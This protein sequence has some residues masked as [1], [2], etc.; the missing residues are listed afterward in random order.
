MKVFLTGATGYIGTAIAEQL[1]AA[2]HSVAGL[3]RNEQA[4]Q[5]L[6]DRGIT[7]VSG[8]LAADESLHGAMEGCDAVIHA[9]TTNDPH[10]DSSAI[11]AML[12]AVKGKNQP[13]IYTS[14]VWVLGNTG[15]TPADENAPLHPP[16]I[17][18]WR[19]ELERRV[20]HSVHDGIRGMVIRPAMVY[21]RGGGL[22]GMF[23]QSANESGASRYIGDGENRWSMVNVEDLA[24]LYLRVLEK[25]EPGNIYHGAD[26]SA[27]R[28]KE[29][30]EAASFGAGAGGATASWH[31]TDAYKRLGVYL[32][33]AMLLDQVVSGEKGKRLLGWQPS[34]VS[35]VEDLRFGSY[36]MAH[37]NP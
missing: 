14:G 29:I 1:E 37:I 25:G 15:D 11:Y 18:E 33:D 16:L 17:V 35:L 23:V 7:P 8:D 32:V 36:A 27:F 30:A 34:A 31:V 5:L 26:G 22:P 20:L 28:T 9:G 12:H 10:E 13:F 2:G 21:G 4:E 19:P 3:A 6:K 24:N